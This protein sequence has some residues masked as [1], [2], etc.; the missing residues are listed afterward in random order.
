MS[1]TMVVPRPLPTIT[2]AHLQ[3][4][5]NA[6]SLSRPSSRTTRRLSPPRRLPTV[7]NALC[8]KFCKTAITSRDAVVPSSVVPG[9]RGFRGFTGKASLFTE[10]QNI[11]LQPP[12][13]MLMT[14]G[15]HTLQ[16]IDCSMCNSQYLGFKIVKSCDET[17]ERGSFFA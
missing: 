3:D 14:S 11:K 4:L 1:A 2:E 17:V 13:K 7:P 15:C 5:T 9:G 10:V 6:M 16:Q 8:C 12:K